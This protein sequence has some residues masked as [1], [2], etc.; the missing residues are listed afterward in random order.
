[1]SLKETTPFFKKKVPLWTPSIKTDCWNYPFLQ[2]L[3]KSKEVRRGFPLCF[4]QKLGKDKF[5]NPWN[6]ETSSEY[7]KAWSMRSHQFILNPF[8]P[9]WW[10]MVKLCLNYFWSI[11]FHS[12]LSLTTEIT[13]KNYLQVTTVTKF[14]KSFS[15]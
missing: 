1:M 2:K 9:C 13:I 8:I 12:T 10:L 14:A 4:R 15:P 11:F 3:E 5:A 7:N 6:T